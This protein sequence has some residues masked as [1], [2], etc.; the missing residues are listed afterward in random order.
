MTEGPIGPQ[1]GME[2]WSNEHNYGGLDVVGLMCKYAL[3]NNEADSILWWLVKTP[4]SASTSLDA[5]STA[6]LDVLC[7]YAVWRHVCISLKFK[8][9]CLLSNNNKRFHNDVL[10]CPPTCHGLGRRPRRGCY[11]LAGNGAGCDLLGRPRST[12]G[13]EALTA[14][15]YPVR[16]YTR[17]HGCSQSVRDGNNS[18]TWVFVNPWFLLGYLIVELLRLLRSESKT[19]KRL[20]FNDRLPFKSL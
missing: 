1:P 3:N 6:L 9:T 16:P 8:R 15:L 5:F 10:W 2:I 20:N 17:T 14:S 7:V 18:K 11:W 19:K 4:V 13:P 12:C